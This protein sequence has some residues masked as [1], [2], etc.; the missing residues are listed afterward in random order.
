MSFVASKRLYFNRS[1]LYTGSG[2]CDCHNKP[3]WEWSI[4]QKSFKI[5]IY[6]N[7]YQFSGISFHVI[8]EYAALTINV[9]KEVMR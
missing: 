9:N 6:Y 1:S 5:G 3:N 8:H 4:K 2:M 7:V